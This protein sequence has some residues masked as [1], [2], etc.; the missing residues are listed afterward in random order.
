[1]SKTSCP[2]YRN[3]GKR[4]GFFLG[5]VALE[6]IFACFVF[7]ETGGSSAARASRRAIPPTGTLLYQLASFTSMA[8]T[9]DAAALTLLPPTDTLPGQIVMVTGIYETMEA[10]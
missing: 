2:T 1:M 10:A 6:G 7:L 3:S 9:M 8:E 4:V 5:G